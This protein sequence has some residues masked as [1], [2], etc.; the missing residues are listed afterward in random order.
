MPNTFQLLGLD[1]RGGLGGGGEWWPSGKHLSDHR[2]LAIEIMPVQLPAR[3]SFSAFSTGPPSLHFT[4]ISFVNV[5]IIDV[6]LK[7]TL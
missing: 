1:G 2:V 4:R 3:H 7:G 5:S 6:V